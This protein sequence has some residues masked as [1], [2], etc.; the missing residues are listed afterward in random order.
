MGRINCSGKAG[1]GGHPIYANPVTA[2][3]SESFRVL[4]PIQNQSLIETRRDQMFRCRAKAGR[5]RS[6]PKAC[7]DSTPVVAVEGQVLPAPPRLPMISAYKRTLTMS[8]VH[9]TM[10]G[11]RSLRQATRRV[12]PIRDDLLARQKRLGSFY[13]SLPF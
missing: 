3:L 5:V 12:T 1:F 10:R 8:L 4:E 6:S 2:A 13:A 7:H 9:L 11:D